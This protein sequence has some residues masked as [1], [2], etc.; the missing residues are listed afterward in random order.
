MIFTSQK[1][2][3]T[4]YE[5]HCR[6]LLQTKDGA[7]R[8]QSEIEAMRQRIYEMERAAQEEYQAFYSV[9]GVVNRTFVEHSP[10]AGEPKGATQARAPM[11]AER[12][13]LNLAAFSRAVVLCNQQHKAAGAVSQFLHHSTRLNGGCEKFL[14]EALRSAQHEE[15]TAAAVYAAA[16]DAAAKAQD[17]EREA[18]QRCTDWQERREKKASPLRAAL[19][20][21]V[22]RLTAAVSGGNLSSVESSGQDV[23]HARAALRNADSGDED[24]T[25]EALKSVLARRTA[26][27][28]AAQGHA[29]EAHTALLRSQEKIA[30]IKMDACELSAI[31]SYIDLHHAVSSI[32]ETGEA[33]SCPA[34]DFRFI[35]AD[36][37]PAGPVVNG[38]TLPELVK[39]D[40]GADLSVFSTDP[41]E[42][43][44]NSRDAAPVPGVAVSA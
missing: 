42:L 35:H 1:D 17:A 37:S 3:K 15:S 34:R 41:M 2:G 20:A 16:R 26:D 6:K 38:W 25:A 40:H 32:K 27:V 24:A 36:A 21:A 11:F 29:H 18:S 5:N 4:K 7:D 23:D 43:L 10:V 13:R 44:K 9:H 14:S 12:D 19:S 30:Q 31:K 28:S 39:T 33:A 8:L 22:E